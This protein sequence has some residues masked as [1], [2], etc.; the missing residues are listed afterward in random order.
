MLVANSMGSM[1]MKKMKKVLLVSPSCPGWPE[2]PVGIA[3]VLACLEDNNIPF[4]FVDIVTTPDWEQTIRRLLAQNDYLVVASGGL[5]SFYKQFR[6]LVGLVR[7]CAPHVPFLLGGNI[8]KDADEHV[9]FDVIGIDYGING[10]A[11]NSLPQFLEG[12]QKGETSFSGYNGIIYRNKKGDILRNPP[13]RFDVNK[14]N[15]IPAWHHLDTDFYIENSSFAFMGKNLRFMPVLSG[16]GCIGKCGF[17]SPT[18][19]SFK[20][21]EISDLIGEIEWLIEKYDFDKLCFL[22][23]M[24]YPSAKDIVAFCEAY[25][26]VKGRKPW[27]VQLRV[28]SDLD[29]ETLK[30]MKDAGCIAVSAGIESGSDK[31]LKLMNKK[32]TESQIRSFFRN[33]KQAGMPASGTYIV[34]YD[35]ETEKDIVKTI[36]LIIE[37]NISSGEALLFTYQGTKVYEQALERGLI[38]D[39]SKQL[40]AYARSLFSPD[41]PEYFCNLTRMDTDYFFTVAQ[42]EVRRYNKFLYERYKVQNLKLKVSGSW[43]WTTIELSGH[44]IECGSPVNIEYVVFGGQY[45]GFLGTSIGRTTICTNCFS[46]VIYDLYESGDFPDMAAHLKELKSVIGQAES[47]VVCGVNSNLNYLLRTDF[48]DFDYAKIKGIHADPDV[49]GE[50][51]SIFPLINTEEL[52]SLEPDCLLCLDDAESVSKYGNLFEEKGKEVPRIVTLSSEH[53]KKTLKQKSCLIYK[54]NKLS[55]ALLGISLRKALNKVV[56][57]VR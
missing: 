41:A 43:R 53:F 21:R 7:E 35:G 10:E 37:E 36:D 40:D 13:V 20:K 6:D 34:G 50:R 52:L 44:C 8:T 15:V 4:D 19:G 2:W 38:K 42:R 25:I 57:L 22:N 3:Y 39:E 29:V 23:E 14:H 5:I 46:P 28:D 27:F 26:N 31:I 51:Y 16:R 33:C 49:H 32:T 55:L 17:C 18:V 56:G 47:L 9:L 30:I 48:L 24:F 12:L 54:L 11:E 45:M 1:K